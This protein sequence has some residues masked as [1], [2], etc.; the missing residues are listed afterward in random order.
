MC[1][2]IQP[3]PRF[4]WIL[5]ISVLFYLY[6]VLHI[7]ILNEFHCERKRIKCVFIA[8]FST[9]LEHCTYVRIMP[10]VTCTFCIYIVYVLFELYSYFMNFSL[11]KTCSCCDSV[12][13]IKFPDSTV[14]VEKKTKYFHV[15]GVRSQD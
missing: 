11:K 5:V 9:L 1:V 7:K 6:V 3:N 12:D 2:R 14:L 4:S 8:P 10:Q 13:V 15:V